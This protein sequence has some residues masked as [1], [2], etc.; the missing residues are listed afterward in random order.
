MHGAAPQAT[1]YRS[2]MESPTQE[3]PLTPRIVRAV[4]QGTL[5]REARRRLREWRYKPRDLARHPSDAEGTW[6]SRRINGIAKQLGTATSYLE[7]GVEAGFTFEAVA[8]PR[9]V[10][11]DP[12]PRFVCADLPSGVSV[13]VETSDEYFASLEPEVIFDLVF[14]DGL[15]TYE[16]TYRD[17]IN[18]L[19]HTHAR[20]V[21]VVDDVVPSDAI[22]AMR[23]LAA[24]HAERARSNSTDFRW[25]G[26]VFRL[27]PLIR[28]HHPELGMRT[29]VHDRDN[30]QLVI[31]RADPNAPST[32]ISDADLDRYRTYTYDETFEHGVPD[33]FRPGSEDEIVQSLIRLLR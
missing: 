19:R 16:Q 30:D 25:H 33:F 4:R 12:N 7:I 23:D 13:R 27:V 26:D 11:V 24:S 3:R 15:H 20:S 21:I 17:L 29:I 9:R 8:M 6:S 2:A 1:R 18:A 31:W 32:P 5:L 22:S 28:D 10:A 14:L